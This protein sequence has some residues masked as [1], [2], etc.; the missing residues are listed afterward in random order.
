[1]AITNS[2]IFQALGIILEGAG[3]LLAFGAFG[4]DSK[5]WLESFYRKTSYFPFQDDLKEEGFQFTAQSWLIGLGL[6]FQL[7]GLFV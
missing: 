4:S 7:I 6:L 1:M 2:V 3:L 5:R